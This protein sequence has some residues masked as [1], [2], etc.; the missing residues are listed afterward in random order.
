MTEDDGPLLEA[1]A[2]SR[3]AIG[4]SAFTEATE[5]RIVGRRS[6]RVQDRDVDL[7]RRTVDLEAIDAAV[8]G[9]TV[10]SAELKAHGHHACRARRSP[11]PW[12]ASANTTCRAIAEHYGVGFSAVAAIQRRM[13][14]A[15]GSPGGGG[16]PVTAIAEQEDIVYSTSLT[17]PPAR[18]T[19]P[20]PERAASW[21]RWSSSFCISNSI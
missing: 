13:A 5:A 1:M 18:R 2:A 21:A 20:M 9:V 7:P 19:F 3:Y 10:D 16:N 6:N 4:S 8:R 17:L 15:A 11:L 14:D 12:P